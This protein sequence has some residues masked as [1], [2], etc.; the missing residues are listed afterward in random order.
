LD[1]WVAHTEIMRYHHIDK[2]QQEIEEQM[3][4]LRGQLSLD[5]EALNG[6]QFQ[7]KASRVPHQL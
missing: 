5:Y 2:E 6:I 1:D 3:A 7:I 4:I